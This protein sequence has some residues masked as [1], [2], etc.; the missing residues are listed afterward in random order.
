MDGSIRPSCR[1]NAC[2]LVRMHSNALLSIKST[3]GNVDY[4]VVAGSSTVY[5]KNSRLDGC[6]M[7]LRQKIQRLKFRMAPYFPRPFPP[8]I[9]IELSAK[10]QL[11]CK[12]CPYGTGG[13]DKSMQG[14]MPERMAA[15]ALAQGALYGA[16]TVK[17]NFR[18]EP[19]LSTYLTNMVCYAKRLGY[20]ETMINTNLTAFSKRRLKDLCK[21]GLDTMIVSVDG[22]RK[23]TYEAIRKGGSF[24]TLVHNLI[25]VQR[26]HPRPWLRIQMVVQKA[27]EHEVPLMEVLFKDLCDEIVYQDVMDRG[28]GEQGTSPERQWCHQPWQRL[29]IAWDGTVFGC[30]G[31]WNNECPIGNIEKDTLKDI[32]LGSSMEKLR[33]MAKDP[34]QGFPCKDCTVGMSY[35]RGAK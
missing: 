30:C 12:M 9:D 26:Q 28:A 14:M 2:D 10:C 27:N 21:A 32:W 3:T 24:D 29:V 19:G 5:S 31:N 8:H 15:V 4:C 20:V 6:V 1:G 34:N 25:F 35:K 18:G 22:A 7:N 13:F 11:E 17:F 33:E 23:K 16:K